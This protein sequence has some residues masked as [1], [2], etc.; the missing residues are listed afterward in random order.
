VIE[1]D[2]GDMRSWLRLESK[3]TFSCL[4]SLLEDISHEDQLPKNE[5]KRNQ[6]QPHFLFFGT[7]FQSFGNLKLQHSR[8][9]AEKQRS[10]EA[11]KQR[12]REAEK[13]RSREAEK[14]KQRSREAEKQ[15]RNHGMR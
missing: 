15:K 2:D 7:N 10:R 11:E 8:R 6:R 3:T 12:S 5:L 1:N 4:V 13:Q 14:Q 9:E